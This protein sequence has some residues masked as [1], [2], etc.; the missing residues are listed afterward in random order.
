MKSNS[1]GKT[2]C[3]FQQISRVGPSH[4]QEI[5]CYVKMKMVSRVFCQMT[6]V[7]IT[8]T[9]LDWSLVVIFCCFIDKHSHLSSPLLSSISQPCPAR[10]LLPPCN[11]KPFRCRTGGPPCLGSAHPLPHSSSFPP[12]NEAFECT[13]TTM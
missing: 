10:V 5:Y 3:E 8:N 6:V 7:N 2:V 13:N 4:R 11:L 12:K 9:T 1:G